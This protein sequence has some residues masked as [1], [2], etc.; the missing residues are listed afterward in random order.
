MACA[1]SARSPRDHSGI[2]GEYLWH[3][4]EGRERR[5]NR[6]HQREDALEGCYKLFSL[7]KQCLL[8]GSCRDQWP[9]STRQVS[10]FFNRDKTVTFG[11]YGALMMIARWVILLSESKSSCNLMWR[12]VNQITQTKRK[13]SDHAHA[14]PSLYLK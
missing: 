4:A 11:W 13:T 1:T 3:F 9:K 2:I 7:R 8:W 14:M 10:C 5:C 12:I 6:L